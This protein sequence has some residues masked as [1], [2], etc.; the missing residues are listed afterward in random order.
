MPLK[1]NRPKEQ[2]WKATLMEAV[3]EENFL[4]PWWS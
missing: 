1:H 2:E 4:R 3:K